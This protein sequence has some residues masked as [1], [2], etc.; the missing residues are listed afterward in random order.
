VRY[1]TREHTEALE[2]LCGKHRLLGARALLDER[3]LD[4]RHADVAGRRAHELDLTRL[5]GVSTLDMV[6]RKHEEAVVAEQERVPEQALDAHPAVQ[7]RSSA[8]GNKPLVRCIVVTLEPLARATDRLLGLPEQGKRIDRLGRQH[9]WPRW[10][11]PLGQAL[12]VV[13]R[14]RHVIDQAAIHLE[15]L[16]DD[17]CK[18]IEDPL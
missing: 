14:D 12:G 17:A 6:E 1:A 9:V 18:S 16:A 11:D 4:E 2:L 15:G 5:P 10:I 3:N 8:I 7:Q 13:L